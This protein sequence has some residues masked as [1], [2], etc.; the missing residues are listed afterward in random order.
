MTDALLSPRGGN[1]KVLE[2]AL[3]SLETR[4]QDLK[5]RNQKLLEHIQN[6]ER[7]NQKELDVLRAK[8]EE[9]KKNTRNLEDKNLE[10]KYEN[11]SLKRKEKKYLEQI[12]KLQ[13]SLRKYQ[14][15]K[16]EE[17]GSSTSKSARPSTMNNVG[18]L[19]RISTSTTGSD[20]AHL[21]PPKALFGN[22]NSL[23]E[24]SPCSINLD[25]K[26][27]QMFEDSEET[28]REFKSTRTQFMS[29][30]NLEVR[31]NVFNSSP[32]A[33]KIERRNSSSKK[34]F[35]RRG[36]LE[37]Q[38]D[39]VITEESPTPTSP[40][41]KLDLLDLSGGLVDKLN[42]ISP[43]HL[44]KKTGMVDV[45]DPEYVDKF[46]KLT[47]N[48][49]SLAVKPEISV[50]EQQQ[51]LPTIGSPLKTEVDSP[52]GKRSLLKY[53]SKSRKFSIFSASSPNVPFY[54]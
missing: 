34:D 6:R 24:T 33:A 17:R 3:E 44:K 43:Q 51:P 25:L 19:E 45:E 10:L 27:N 39:E 37:L 38:F 18:L 2:K 36:T 50:G 49:V 48:I 9:N 29:L 13:A 21:S 7:D 31:S 15:N 12:E 42:K 20:T 11:D 30:Q 53:T 16:P 8:L 41:D 28:E 23:Q 4:Y 5:N 26:D 35:Q 32:K 47:Q 46:N 54:S 40:K 14:G 52:D 1:T 22:R